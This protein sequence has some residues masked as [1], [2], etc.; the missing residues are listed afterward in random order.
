MDYFVYAIYNL[1]NDKIYI[2][3]TVDLVVRLSQH[4]D[5]SFKK[6]TSRYSGNWVFVYQ[7]SLSSRSEAIKR[8]KQLKSYKGREFIREK[9]GSLK[10]SGVSA[11][12]RR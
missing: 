7:E 5:S 9:I 6:F 11:S 8:E 4:N 2:G 10:N 1:Q 12:W 3:Q